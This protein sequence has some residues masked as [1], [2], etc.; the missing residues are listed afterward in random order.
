MSEPPQVSLVIACYNEE[1]YLRQHVQAIR[2]VMAGTIYS[3]ELIFVEDASQDGTRAIVEELVRGNLDSRAIYHDRNQGRGQTVT[4]GI[5]AARGEVVGFIDIDLETPAIYIPPLVQTILSGA[6]VATAWRVYR[7]RLNSLG[8][9]FLTRGYQACLKSLFRLQLRDTETG[10]KFF[11]R[12]VILPV[13]EM[14]QDPYWFWDTEIMVY[15]AL[16][17][18]RI[19]EMPT[20]FV[21]HP[22]FPSTV[23]PVRD[24]WRQLRAL[25]S[26]R[27][28]LRAEGMLELPVEPRPALPPPGFPCR[29][30]RES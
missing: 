11:R 8:R 20:L 13:L 15:S 18:L 19:T 29:L 14:C 1:L 23:Q 24:S 26:F 4:D 7:F 21:R 27:R 28:R 25:L 2:E 17:G 30:D 6:D 9:W 16:L 10:C 22:E 12:A 3:Y 5:R